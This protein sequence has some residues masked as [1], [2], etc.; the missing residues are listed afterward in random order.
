MLLYCPNYLFIIPGGLTFLAGFII[1][2]LLL[3]GP[4]TFAG[5]TFDFHAM[6]FGSMMTLLGFQLINL[7]F[8]AKSYA[9]AEGYER[10][11]RFFAKFYKVF[12]LEKGI[13]IGGVFILT[14]LILGVSII[15]Q[16]VLFG[17]VTQERKELLAITIIVIGIQTVFS[18]FLISLIGM[19][20]RD[21]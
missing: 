18:S 21:I 15:R 9:L 1:M 8:F 3:Q 10:K 2:L 12:D 6:I 19:K 11:G 5:H 14:G 20:T 17:P 7:G 4:V 16:W 13:L